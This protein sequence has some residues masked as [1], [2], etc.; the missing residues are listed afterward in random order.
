MNQGFSKNENSRDNSTRA[1]IALRLAG[2]VGAASAIVESLTPGQVGNP[3]N[4]GEQV[5]R[6]THDFLKRVLKVKEIE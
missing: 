4:D 5:F 1:D 2:F 3:L 6:G